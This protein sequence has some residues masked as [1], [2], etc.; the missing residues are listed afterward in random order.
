MHYKFQLEAHLNDRGN[1]FLEEL[2]FEEV[3]PVVVNEVNEE[4]LDVRA[5]LVLICHY[6]QTTISVVVGKGCVWWM[7]PVGVQLYFRNSSQWT[8]T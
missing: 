6:H 2:M 7:L 4:A 3:G 1:E 5:I 8:Q